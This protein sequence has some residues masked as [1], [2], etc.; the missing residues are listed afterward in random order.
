M[1]KFSERNGYVNPSDIIIRE[2][3]T[4]EIRNAILDFLD[5]LEAK[6]LVIF[7]NLNNNFWC[8]F[9]HQRMI[10][11]QSDAIEEYCINE[12]VWYKIIDALEFILDGLKF[13]DFTVVNRCIS[14][15]NEA[16]ALRNF[17]YRIVDKRYIEEITSK[18]EIESVEEALNTPIDGVK[19]HLNDALKLLSASN[20]TPNYRNSIKESISAVECFC[21]IKTGKNT[22]GDAITE[23]KKKG[24]I[25]N[26]QMETGFKNLYNYTNNKDTGIRHSI[27]DDKNSPTADEAIYMLVTCSAFIN[28][29]KTKVE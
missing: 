4:P 26:S 28:Y 8:K 2:R 24:L 23:L 19:T 16:F 12:S 20:E 3:I 22:L 13:Y 17:A 14:D 11:G 6:A 21:R 15:L 18:E 1:E 25:I 9:L 29:L 27:M 7:E 10:N 5:S